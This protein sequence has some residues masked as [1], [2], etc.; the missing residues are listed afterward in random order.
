MLISKRAFSVIFPNTY[1][2]TCTY[3]YIHTQSQREKMIKRAVDSVNYEN[4]WVQI[5]LS[6]YNQIIFFYRNSQSLSLSLSVVKP[7]FRCKLKWMRT[8]VPK[9]K[10]ELQNTGCVVFRGAKST[11]KWG[12]SDICILFVYMDLVQGSNTWWLHPPVACNRIDPQAIR[13]APPRNGSVPEHRVSFCS[14]R[15]ILSSSQPAFFFFFVF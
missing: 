4:H 15:R 10:L 6:F 9:S 8:L 7:H 2:H 14:T 1:V 13:V 12:G 3:I 5:K 11:C